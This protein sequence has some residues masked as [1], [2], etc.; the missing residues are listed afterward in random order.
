MKFRDIPQLT[1]CSGYS[2]HVG[3]DYLPEHVLRAVEEG[4]LNVD[5]DFQRGHVWTLEQKVRYVEYVLKGGQYG[6]DLWLNCPDW[7]E[8]G[9]TDYV[10]VDG[11][12]RL[13]AALGFLNNEFPIFDGNYR[14]DFE[15]KPNMLT[16]NFCWHVNQLQT[17]DA[18]LVW[19]IDLNMGGTPH[20]EE[21]ERVRNLMGRPWEPTTEQ[22]RLAAAGMDRPIFVAVREKEAVRAAE[23]K[24][25][26]DA[27]PLAKPLKPR[28]GKRR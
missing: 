11:K 22:E 10:L 28:K 19:Y 2:V 7:R 20:T 23:E 1:Q 3:W 5:P 21:I 15:D 14:R 13:S 9:R 12:Q 4:G 26:R 6:R 27:L 24:A 17:R 18:V 8:G 25:V 16:A